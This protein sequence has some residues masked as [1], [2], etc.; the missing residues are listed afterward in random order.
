MSVLLDAALPFKLAWDATT[1][2]PL[3]PLGKAGPC[4]VC[5]R[6]LVL[7]DPEAVLVCGGCQAW[8]QDVMRRAL[9]EAA[10]R[11]HGREALAKILAGTGVRVEDLVAHR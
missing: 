6:W 11:G 8:A 10:R 9:T 2:W 7:F 4:D 1:A 5:G 3:P